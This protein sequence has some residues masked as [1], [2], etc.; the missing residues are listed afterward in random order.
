MSSEE[1]SKIVYTRY[2]CVSCV[3]DVF[4]Y[5][6]G[7][8]TNKHKHT[9]R[10]LKNYYQKFRNLNIACLCIKCQEAKGNKLILIGKWNIQKPSL[11]AMCS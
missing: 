8:I 10:I 3:Q 1:R 11:F 4:R 7:T 2:S 5:C 6:G 9:K